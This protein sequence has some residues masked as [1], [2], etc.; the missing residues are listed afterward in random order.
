MREDDIPIVAF[1]Q[2]IASILTPHIACPAQCVDVN[3]NGRGRGS[4]HGRRG[5]AV[6]R[7][8]QRP[9]RDDRVCLVQGPQPDG[10]AADDRQAPGAAIGSRSVRARRPDAPTVERRRLDG[11]RASRHGGETA[12]LLRGRYRHAAVEHERQS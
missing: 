11:G 3:R 1:T 6:R 9:T 2:Q 5:G 10:D 4:G 8:R 7:A 12:W